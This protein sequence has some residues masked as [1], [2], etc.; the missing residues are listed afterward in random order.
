MSDPTFYITTPIYYVNDV[1][2]IGH[3]Y[4][5]IAADVAA[6]YHR[7][8]GEKV[9]FLTGTDEHG[10]K[11]HQEAVKRGIPTQ[12][13]VDQVVKRFQDLWKKL[14]ISHDDF[15]RTTEARH[16]TV[17]QKVLADLHDKKEI[18]QGSYEGWYCT[19][20]ERFWTEKDLSEGAC[21]DCLRPVEKIV[22]TN[23][24]FKMGRYRDWLKEHIA[25]NPDFIKPLSRRNEVAGFL[26]KPLEDLCISRPKGRLSWGIPLPFDDNYVTYVWFDALINY[27]SAKQ[28]WPADCHL[29]GK[30]ILTPHSVYWPIMLKAA[31][32][33]PP[34]TIFAHGW[35]TVEG[36][37][38]SKSKG[39][40]VDPNEMVDEFGVDAFRYF[41]LREVP[42]G[43]DGDFSRDALIGRINSDLANSLGNL[44]HRTLTMIELF[45]GGDIPPPIETKNR[46][47]VESPLISKVKG[48][49][50]EIKDYM[51]ELRFHLALFEIWSVIDL[52]NRAIE[53]AAPWKEENNA[54]KNNFLYVLA[55]TLRIVGLSL[56]PF[57]PTTA[58][59]ISRQLGL[60]VDFAQ[61]LL[62][63]QGQWGWLRG[64]IRIKKGDP[65]FPRIEKKEAFM[66]DRDASLRSEGQITIEEFKKV[67]LRV[68]K[69]LTAEKVEGARKLLKLQVDIGKEKRQVVA[70]I[71][72]RYTPEEI[73]GKKVVFVANLKSATI[74]GVES[75][76]M[77]LA[78]GEKEVE[79]LAIF[80]NDVEVGT[81]VK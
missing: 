3:A 21:P 7:L 36:E 80:L 48:L 5:T 45:H 40:V 24:F 81:R 49:S 77:V 70:G 46:E 14:S 61:P 75:Q 55:E 30:D 10:Q 2:H 22:E 66:E 47:T 44:L 37:K 4:T 57:M 52:A 18:Y 42:F 8:L 41:L 31:G 17:V 6:R 54:T 1:P 39:N 50:H 69:I 15:I 43:L 72:A 26:E 63:Q 27:I 68:G 71:A 19:P 60:Q 33:E 65:L 12:E 23:Y 64:G 28:W 56:Y 11:V 74:F 58:E 73:I 38:M 79:A 9:F 67:D 78:A 25:K 32:L 53:Q 16:K 62:S 20:C 13:Y 29:I 35:W 76:G 59:E 51:K 34:K